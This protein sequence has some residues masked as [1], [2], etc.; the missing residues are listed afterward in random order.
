MPVRDLGD[1][2]RNIPPKFSS[3][4][5]YI[6]KYIYLLDH[7]MRRLETRPLESPMAEIYSSLRKNH[8]QYYI[9]IGPI[10]TKL[11]INE[12]DRVE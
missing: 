9:Q 8:L 1:G 11:Y 6:Y 2:G 5:N 10:T 4:G 12:G 7:G 3:V